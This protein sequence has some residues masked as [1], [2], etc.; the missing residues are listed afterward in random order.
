MEDDVVNFLKDHNGQYDYNGLYTR[1]DPHRTGQIGTVLQE[2]IGYGAV[3]FKDGI[4]RLP[5]N[6]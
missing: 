1:F 6:K 4:V 5:S 2:M 3:R